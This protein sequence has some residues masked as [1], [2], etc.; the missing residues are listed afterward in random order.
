MRIISKGIVKKYSP[1][2][3][4]VTNLTTQIDH[5]KKVRYTFS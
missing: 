3:K 4:N 5:E 1:Y 2:F